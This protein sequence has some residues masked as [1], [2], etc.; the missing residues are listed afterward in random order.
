MLQVKQS[1]WKGEQILKKFFG[2]FPIVAIAVIVG[3][4]SVSITAYAYYR[5][6][7]AVDVSAIQTA[8]CSM[9]VKVITSDTQ[10]V[11]L[12]DEEETYIESYKFTG[13]EGESGVT[14][15]IV[16]AGTASSGY[17]EVIVKDIDGNQKSY[18][19]PT[20]VKGGNH[21]FTILGN[22]DTEVQF[23]SYWGKHDITDEEQIIA[24][25]E[26]IATF[27]PVATVSP[28]PSAS[29][30]PS[31]SPSPTPSASPS[32]T[33]S[34]EASASPEPSERPT[35]T[36]EASACP[37]P[38]ASPS[39]APDV[40]VS[41]EASATASATPSEAPTA[42]PMP[43]AEVIGSETSSPTPEVDA[44]AMPSPTSEV[45]ANTTPSSSP[46]AMPEPTTE[47]TASPT[48]SP[49]AEED[50]GTENDIETGENND[51]ESESIDSDGTENSTETGND[52][53][54]QGESDIE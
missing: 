31:V 24:I 23:I 42:T 11:S 29:P 27:V 5:L 15:C 39:A 10:A 37:T 7:L 12:L 3:V 16:G 38:S 32:P 52:T 43:T 34:A 8:S 48:E 2:K 46:S 14:F 18:Y 4:C 22:K 47:V 26:K 25:G 40:S 20:I 19:T 17:C 49:E 28:S 51:I 13:K 50:A 30:S 35:P 33:P 6:T 45:D 54:G 41:P 44:S 21:Y 53:E 36:P 9:L 1:I